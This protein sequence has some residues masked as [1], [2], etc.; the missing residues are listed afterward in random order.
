VGEREY[1]VRPGACDAVNARG[2]LNYAPTT[3]ADGTELY[4]TRAVMRNDLFVIDGIYVSKRPTPEHAWGPPEKIEAI[5]GV[6]EAPTLTRDGRRLYYHKQD[7]RRMVIHRVTR[8][9]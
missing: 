6:V 5:S 9:D 3:S 1:R 8:R 7:G 4:F 2:T